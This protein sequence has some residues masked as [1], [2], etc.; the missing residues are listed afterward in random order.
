MKKQLTIMLCVVVSIGISYAQDSENKLQK[1]KKAFQ[2][3]AFHLSGFG[4]LQFNFSEY[5]ER[6]M[7][8]TRVNNSI[9]ITRA[10]ISASGKIGDNKQFGYMILYDFGPNSKLYEIYGE[11]YSSKGFNV[12]F[13]QF[14]VPFTIEN[15]I[16]L[17]NIETINPSR[18]VSAMSGGT[19]DFN[20]WDIDGR[21][22][23]KT[24]R[25]A[26]L[27]MYGSLLP[28]KDFYGLEYYAGFSNGTGMNTKDNNNRK[29]FLA[30]IYL[31][32]SKEFKLGGSVY[33]GK[34]PDYMQYYLLGNSLNTNR[35]TVGAEYKGKNFY[36]RAEYI[37]S[38]DAGMRRNGY[39]GL[40]ML[41]PV[42]DKWEIIG[43]YDYF[44]ND[45]LYGK[46]VIRDVTIG[47]NY[48]FAYMSR[49]QLNYIYTDNKEIGKNHAFAAQLQVYF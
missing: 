21:T 38:N 24:G 25:D 46:N 47:L 2:S 12:R 35:W 31:N 43:K 28:T 30:T 37:Q 7:V 44:N 13:G 33:F 11:W 9:D 15:P 32:T 34:Y 1:F 42:P 40:M 22:V 39:Y 4:H 19:G 27:L 8:P 26:G 17:S 41:K 23:N 48:Y 3:E 6:A 45:V 20:Q 49:I 29:D 14:K 16:T 36:S 10:F 5:S 18:P